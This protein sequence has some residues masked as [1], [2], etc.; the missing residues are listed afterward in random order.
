MQIILRGPSAGYE[1]EHVARLFFSEAVL[2]GCF[3]DVVHL[4]A[5]DPA[6]LQ[7]LAGRVETLLG[8]ANLDPSAGCLS[9]QRQL[10]AAT[11]ARNALDDALAAGQQGFGLDAVS[12]CVD[13]ALHAL[14]ELTGEA[15]DEAVI[16]E[17]FSRFCVG[18]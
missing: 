14:Y 2:A 11:A 13:E 10:A 3:S 12:V 17:V 9:G 16:E 18:K 6:S 8:V 4:S 1:A 5:K 7:L 15:A